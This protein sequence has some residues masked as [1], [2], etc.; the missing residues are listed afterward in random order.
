MRIAVIVSFEKKRGGGHL[1]RGSELVRE[2]RRKGIE[3][4]LFIEGD[5]SFEDALRA[6]GRDL[7]ELISDTGTEEDCAVTRL[8]ELIV[9]DRFALPPSSFAKLKNLGP[10]VGID[11]S[12]PKRADMDF[13]I[14]ILQIVPPAPGLMV[15]FKGRTEALKPN[16]LKPALIR[17]PHNKKNTDFPVPPVSGARVLIVFGIENA[18][19]LS[20]QAEQAVLT[21]EKAKITVITGIRS[22][23]RPQDIYDCRPSDTHTDESASFVRYAETIPN[24]PERLFEFDLVITHFGLCCFECLAAGTPVI[25]AAPTALHE[26]LARKAG[27]LTTGRDMKKLRD[28]CLSKNLA[29]AAEASGNTAARYFSGRSKPESPADFAANFKPLIFRNCPVC[30]RDA[31]PVIGRALERTYRRCRHCGTYTMSRLTPVPVVYSEAYFFEDYARQYGRTYIEDF[32]ALTSLAEKRLRHIKKL[33]PSGDLLDIGCAYG[34]FLAAASRAGYKPSG[35]DPSAGAIRYVNET[36]GIPAVEASV[37]EA[38]FDMESESF[39][40]I[41]LWY[42][43]EHFTDPHRVLSEIR[44]LLKP[45][46]ILAFSTPSGRGVSA[47]FARKRFLENSPADHWTI[48]DPKRIRR[49]LRRSGFSFRKAVI[50]GHH[51]ERLPLIGRFFERGPARHLALL[52]SKIFSLGETFEVY[53]RKLSKF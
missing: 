9:T 22:E 32:P 34:P 26:R 33:R 17:F 13:L 12:G 51:P 30:G 39:D 24:L 14:D 10:I 47:R 45:A 11:E 16:F 15:F 43:I 28:I 7:G 6:A 29:P 19:N 4:R 53:A 48:W 37:P 41:S 20:A 5:R 8:P 31:G 35:I 21:L 38:L 1:M 3:A 36:L 25:L 44:R 42:V 18:K 40:V 23:K 46:G 2:L 49:A 50:T 52:V 27:F